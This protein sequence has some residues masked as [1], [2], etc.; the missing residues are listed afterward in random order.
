MISTD[1]RTTSLGASADRVDVAIVHYFYPAGP[2]RR[3]GLPFNHGVAATVTKNW[4]RSC[5]GTAL[6]SGGG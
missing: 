1:L 4:T 5:S 6:Q 2:R 3:R